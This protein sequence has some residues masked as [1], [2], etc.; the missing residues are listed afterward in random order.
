[1]AK[2]LEIK[3]ALLMTEPNWSAD[4]DDNISWKIGSRK[5]GIFGGQGRKFKIRLT[6][7]DTGRKIEIKVNF[8]IEK[9][10]VDETDDR[11][12]GE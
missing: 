5:E 8:G 6:S 11:D 1:M 4:D 12:I 3:P 9:I 2:H 10:K 7:L